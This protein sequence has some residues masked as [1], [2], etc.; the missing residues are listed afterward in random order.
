MSMPT[1]KPRPRFLTADQLAE[2]RAIINGDEDDARALG[3]AVEAGLVD[4]GLGLG[5]PADPRPHDA[6]RQLAKLAAGARELRRL[7]PA[8]PGLA[9]LRL[10]G[11]FGGNRELE[12]AGMALDDLEIAAKRAGA[13]LAKWWDTAPPKRGRGR[14]AGSAAPEHVLA[15]AILRGWRDGWGPRAPRGR[16]LAV[17]KLAHAWAGAP[18]NGRT[19]LRALLPTAPRARGRRP[20]RPE[21]VGRKIARR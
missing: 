5:L 21:S 18:D 6:T 1:R 8:P 14:P 16:L 11:A 17:V 12:A 20:G 15:R 19:M 9:W 4:Y 3:V 7:L 10:A 2:L 13:E